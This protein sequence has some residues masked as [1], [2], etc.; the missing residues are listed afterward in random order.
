[1]PIPPLVSVI[2]PT[3]NRASFLKEAVDSVLNQTYQRIE[4]ILVDD[5][6][7]DETSTIIEPFLNN[8]KVKLYRKTENQG[9]SAARNLGIRNA[10][11]DYISFLDSDDMWQKKK[12]EYQLEFLLNQSEYKACYTDEIWIRKGVRVNQ[13]NKHRKYSGSIYQK[14]LALC[15]ISPSSIIMTKNL[16]DEIG[17]FDESLPAC[18]DYDYWLRLCSRYPVY[19]LEK[20]LIIK[21]GGHSDQLSGK[22]LAMDRFRV[23]ALIKMLNS[24]YLNEDHYAMT[25]DMLLT[26]CEILK[27]GYYKH[28]K[29]QEA[30]YFS[31][32]ID[33]YS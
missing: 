16:I 2:I 33:Q 31:A 7:D 11:G 19:F 10:N 29:K 9:V 6:S 23:A 5:A 26:K 28:G 1:M 12:L 22:Y 27:N 25:K 21:R 32:L 4:L 30:D 3:Y 8:S 13:K 15:I 20:Q 24:H 14:C 17:F 18:E